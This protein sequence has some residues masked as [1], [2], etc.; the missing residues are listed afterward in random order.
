MNRSKRLGLLAGLLVAAIVV[1]FG[2]SRYQTWQEDIK[3]SGEVI[4]ALSVDDVQSLSWDYE[5]ESLAFTRSD[6][7][8]YDGDENFPVDGDRMDSMLTLFENLTAAFV[9]EAPED[10]AQYGLDDPTC[11]IN[12]TAGDTDY[13]ITLGDYSTM[14]AQRYLSIG[15]GNVYLVETDPLDTFDVALSD[16]ILHDTVPTF[17]QVNQFTLEGEETLSVDYVAEGGDSY[18]EDD[19]YY[20]QVDGAQAPL[21]TSR[22]ENYLADL[23]YLGL[24][25]YLTYTADEGDLAAY[26]LDDPELRVTVDYTETDE[27]GNETARTFTLAVS[28]DPDQEPVEDEE[29]EDITAYAR[30]G[31]S[32]LIYQISGADYLALMAAGYDDLR[33]TEILPAD[34]EDLSQVDVTLDGV[35]Y[36][37]TLAEEEE[38]MTL[39]YQ[40]QEVEITDFQTAL[41][42]LAADSFTEE[43][44]TGQEEIALTVHLDLEGQPTVSIVLYRYDGSSCL[45]VV[46]GQPTALVA[47]SAVVDLVEAVNAVV[48]N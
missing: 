8:S 30:V 26:G 20:A 38:G 3:N 7:W 23:E 32:K 31:E 1:T 19:V 47:R 13:T 39:S 48:L 28:R 15:D 18:R 24:T 45:A 41:E 34:F 42:T 11:T 14:D 9:I 46:D 12:L 5:D 4:L 22:V 44:P 35:D 36:T 17:Q 29:A 37:L 6:G 33:H 2:V 27:E 21:D 40:D 25:D 10:V 43:Q 16:L